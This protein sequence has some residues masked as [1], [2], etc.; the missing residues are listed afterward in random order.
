MLKTYVYMLMIY[1]CTVNIYIILHILIAMRQICIVL[2]LI[3]FIFVLSSW[4][5]LVAS[6]IPSNFDILGSSF[7]ITVLASI[8]NLSVL[9]ISIIEYKKVGGGAASAASK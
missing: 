4:S 8:T 6:P 1:P 2:L 7:W 5:L 9:I 3:T